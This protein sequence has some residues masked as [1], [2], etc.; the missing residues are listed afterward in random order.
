MALTIDSNILGVGL[1]TDFAEEFFEV[2]HPTF[3]LVV[4]FTELL[5]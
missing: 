3:P 4:K 1:L 5:G 2:E